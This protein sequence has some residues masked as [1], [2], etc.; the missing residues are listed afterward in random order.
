MKLVKDLNKI[1][2]AT[3]RGL[4]IQEKRNIDSEIKK[5][6]DFIKEAYN[7]KDEL[8][9]KLIGV[10]QAITDLEIIRKLKL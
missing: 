7:K 8:A 3:N 4:L 6:D 9:G 5:I 10:D 1:L 2:K